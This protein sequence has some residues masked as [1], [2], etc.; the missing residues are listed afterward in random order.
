ML[1][2]QTARDGKVI[3]KA[4]LHDEQGPS[5]E[6]AIGRYGGLGLNG[7]PGSNTPPSTRVAGRLCF[8][9]LLARRVSC[10]FNGAGGFLWVCMGLQPVG[11]P[12]TVVPGS[13]SAMTMAP[14]GPMHRRMP[15]M[16]AWRGQRAGRPSCGAGSG[17]TWWWTRLERRS[18][19]QTVCKSAWTRARARRRT[20][21]PGPSCSR[22]RK[23]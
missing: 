16:G 6:T 12:T 17:R 20:I 10:W 13:H 7:R 9:L 18:L 19:S 5:R 23:R 22:S 21:A 2:T 11:A 3:I 8:F 4:I 15:T 14:V 1:W